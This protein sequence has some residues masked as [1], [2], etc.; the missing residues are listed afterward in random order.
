[1]PSIMN[2]NL[3]MVEKMTVYVYMYVLYRKGHF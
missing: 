1:M 2:D 3:I